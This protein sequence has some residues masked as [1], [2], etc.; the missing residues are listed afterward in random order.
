MISTCSHAP[1]KQAP[2]Y[3]MTCKES[4]CQSCGCKCDRYKGM[5]RRREQ[6]AMNAAIIGMN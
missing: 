2:F 1:F 4:F 6:P 5:A 3:C